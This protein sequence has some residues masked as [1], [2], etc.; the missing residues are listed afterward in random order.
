MDAACFNETTLKLF[1]GCVDQTKDGYVTE[2]Q[3]FPLW[4]LSLWYEAWEWLGNATDE[5]EKHIRWPKIT[6]QARS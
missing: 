5:Q 1:S 4:K 3:L 6:S 2:H